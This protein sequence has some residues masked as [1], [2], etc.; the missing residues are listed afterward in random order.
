MIFKNI[1]LNDNSNVL[2]EQAG[3]LYMLKASNDV[4]KQNEDLSTELTKQK[5]TNKT[6]N[7]KVSK[8]EE[9]LKNEKN[10][11]LDSIFPLIGNS[12]SLGYILK[13]YISTLDLCL[14]EYES[15]NCSNYC[16]GSF[17]FGDDRCKC[18]NRRVDYKITLDCDG[19]LCVSI[20]AY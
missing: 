16:G 4:I 11:F 1:N 2:N 8:L 20:E 15:K 3:L 18:G 6:L 14:N 13:K 9:D 17:D 12:S 5:H 10:K 19:T 7:E